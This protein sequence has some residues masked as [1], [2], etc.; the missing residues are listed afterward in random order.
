[1]NRRN[2]RTPSPSSGAGLA[3]VCFIA[4]VIGL[5]VPFA[6]GHPLWGVAALLIP[7]LA[8]VI[9]LFWLAVVCLGILLAVFA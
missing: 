3:V 7:P 4:Y 5:I 6:T 2:S 9:G 1:M 8:L